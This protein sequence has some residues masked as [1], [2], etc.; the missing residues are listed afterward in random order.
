MADGGII[1]VGGLIASAASALGTAVQAAAQSKVFWDPQKEKD[2]LS[3]NVEEIIVD[4]KESVRKLGCIRKDFENKVQRNNMQAPSEMYS[5]WVRLVVEID[6]K[7]EEKRAQYDKQSKEEAF[8]RSSSYVDFREAF[9]KMY[10][11]VKSL[12]EESNQL[13]HKMFVDLLPKPVMHKEGPYNNFVAH[14]KQ[15]KEILNLLESSKVKK[16]GILGTV[17]IGKTTMMRNLNNHEKVA[18]TFEMVIWL[19][20]STEGSRKN[21]TREHLLQTIVTRLKLNTG[22]SSNADEVT[23]TNAHGVAERISMKLQGKKFLLLLDDVKECLNLTEIGIPESNN[24]SKI[25]LTTRLRRVCRKMVEQ[26]IKVTYL[27]LDEA[28]KM[29]QDVLKSSGVLGD[30]EIKKIARRVCNECCGLPLLIQKVASTFKFKDNRTAW[31]DGL[32]NWRKWPEKDREGIKEMYNLLKFCY[33]DLDDEQRQ[34]C[35]LYGALYPEGSW[36]NADYL[37]ECWVAENLLGNDDSITMESLKCGHH[38]LSHLKYVSLLENGEGENQVTMHKFIRHLALY[39][40]EDVPDCNYLVETSK[41]LR[42]PPKVESWTEKKRISFGD[43]KLEQ[44]PASPNCSKLSTLFLQKNLSLEEIPPTFFENMTKLRVLDVS[45]TGI[46]GLP[47]SLTFSKGLKVLYLNNCTNLVELPSHIVA[48]L[49]HLEALDIVGSGINNIPP[50]M[51]NLTKLRRLR[52]SFSTSKNEN[53]TQEVNFNYEVISK[54]PI[55]EELVIN[56]KSHEIWSDDVEENIMKEVATLKEFKS[57]KFFFPDKVVDVIEVVGSQ[58]Y[59]NLRIRVPNATILLSFIERSLWRNV[60]DIENF[61]FYIGSKKPEHPQLPD[62]HEHVR[63]VKYCEIKGR[64]SPI[65]KVLAEAVA[66]ELVDNNKIKQLSDSELTNMNGIQSCL[67]EGCDAIETIV[68][69][70]N[71]VV[72]PSLEHLFI[73]NLPKLESILKSPLQPGSLTKIKT[74]VLSGCQILVQVFPHGSIQQLCEIECL[75]IEKCD[76]IKEIISESDTRR[77]LPVLPKLKKMFL[78]DMRNLSSI[79][80][81][82][83]LEWPSLE[84]LEIFNC[85]RLSKFPFSEVNAK[86]LKRMDVDIAWQDW[87]GSALRW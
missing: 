66:F 39:I 79:C 44:L 65:L 27:S 87:W 3:G 57:L 29:F 86:K 76:E 56:V 82:E 85:P 31:S 45:H 58:K 51:E 11:K 72:L 47:S 40:A 5:E 2:D 18:K 35:F 8:F 21:L 54:L 1:A 78:Q 9:K 17:G 25:V 69:T 28:W 55:L 20:V 75:G 34:K 23:S 63:Y 70:S 80:A 15:I 60:R 53:A 12:G 83:T 71:S 52:V 68:G 19:E 67:I 49:E 77:N 38:V 41:G 48:A 16:I 46:E 14:E 81:I 6:K 30:P 32:N 33:D 61:E 84:E 62:F 42:Q 43:N 74:L 36:I 13:Q 50:H 7:V 10:K 26:I 4:L 59:Q 22:G 64:N 24:G 37:L 73:K